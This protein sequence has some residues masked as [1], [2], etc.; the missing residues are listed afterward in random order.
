MAE[1]LN[2]GNMSPQL[3][4]I[5]M[6]AR[7]SP[8]MRF[9]SLNHALDLDLLREAFRRTRK[10]GA[11]GVDGRTAAEYAERLDDVLGQAKPALK[12]LFPDWVQEERES[13]AITC[14]SVVTHWRSQCESATVDEGTVTRFLDWVESVGLTSLYWTL[15]ASREVG[16]GLGALS[17]AAIA[18]WLVSLAAT[19]EHVLTV[20]LHERGLE[21]SG[22]LLTKLK[23]AWTGSPSVSEAI[24]AHSAK[25]RTGERSFELQLEAI[26]DLRERAPPEV[27][28]SLTAVLVRNH[29]A[30][31]GL[32]A[33]DTEELRE[34]EWEVLAAL[35]LSWN[36]LYPCPA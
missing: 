28:P 29:G 27:V 30:H 23:R 12:I 33:R 8:E 11:T 36:S 35:I 25:T 7:Q 32:H 14:R 21:A 13:A 31:V 2:S 26:R 5:A 19:W 24:H 3:Q 9:T 22:T 16:L 15:R 17:S 20:A 34:L 1:A 4:R 6:L 10:D 18:S